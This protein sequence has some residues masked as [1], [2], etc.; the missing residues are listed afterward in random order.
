MQPV[1]KTRPQQFVTSLVALMLLG[2]HAAGQSASAATST[3]PRVQNAKVTI[4]STMLADAGV[5]EWGFAA[6]LEADGHRVLIDTGALPDTVLRNLQALRL[7]LASV[8]DVVLTH[9]HADHTGG[10][11][12]LRRE[13][14]KQNPRAL[15]RVHV[16]RGVFWSRPGAS[17]REGNPM[18]GVKREFEATGGQFIEHA[19]WSELL[20]GVWLTGPVPRHTSEKNYGFHGDV[21]RVQSPA[22]LVEDNVP[23]DQ[24]VVVSTRDG[25]IV[26]TGCGH[27]G[28]VNILD[29]TRGKLNHAPVYG[30][31]GGLHLFEKPDEQIAWTADEMKKDGVRLFLGAHCTG[32]ESVYQMRARMGL[33]RATAIVG[34]VGASYVSGEGLHPGNIAR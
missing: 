31:L 23:E 26:I 21:G 1:M 33:T 17:G 14:M 25:L 13:L 20:P 2:L 22:G 12:T 6:L 29:Y 18:L 15:A 30:V 11:L 8:E 19:D 32:I 10:L 5:G 7:D 4:L 28:I 9:F 34:A 3:L 27:A 24:S 16:A